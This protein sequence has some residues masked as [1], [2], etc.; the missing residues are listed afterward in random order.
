MHTAACF[1]LSSRPSCALAN[2]EFSFLKAIENAPKAAEPQVL[3]VRF[4]EV[5]C[6]AKG[7]VV[8]SSRMVFVS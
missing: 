3:R 4:G 1:L 6:R 2:D 5:L 8:V 7:K